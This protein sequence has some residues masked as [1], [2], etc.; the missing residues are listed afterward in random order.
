MLVTSAF[1]IIAAVSFM[2]PAARGDCP[3]VI[4][5]AVGRLYP[6]ATNQTCKQE[7]QGGKSIYEVN[8]TTK[9]GEKV[10]LDMAP[11]GTVIQVE[12]Q[13]SLDTVPSAVLKAFKG[14]YPGAKVSGA[15][16]QTKADGKVFFEIAFVAGG[17]KKEATF[18]TDG[19]FVEE[20]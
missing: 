15:E 13:V 3:Q 4:K 16:K 18:A 12:E 1:A 8:L 14:K 17:A 5:A 9:A 10:E 6:G 19:A 2:A 11:D 20:E 7:M